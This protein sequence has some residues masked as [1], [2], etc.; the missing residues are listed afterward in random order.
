MLQSAV[1]VYLVRKPREDVDFFLL[2]AQPV[3]TARPTRT[4][5]TFGFLFRPNLECRIG[6]VL[7]T[8][9]VD[10]HNVA[11][12]VV[13]ADQYESLPGRIFNRVALSQSTSDLVRIRPNHLQNH[14][15]SSLRNI[16]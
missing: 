14:K 10:R 16:T 5:A 2:C 15:K 6:D 1:R 13:V 7:L 11:G 9:P 4:S 3:I 12:G 8:A